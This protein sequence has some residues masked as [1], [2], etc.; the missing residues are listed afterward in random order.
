T[1]I[2]MIDHRNLLSHTYDPVNFEEAVVAIHDRYL[3][4]LQQVR[5]LL[6]DRGNE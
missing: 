2:A 1:W 3:P 4:T 6:A 5:N